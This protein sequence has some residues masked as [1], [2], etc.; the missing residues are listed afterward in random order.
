MYGWGRRCSGRDSTIER[1]HGTLSSNETLDAGEWNVT[2]RAAEMSEAEP[3][4][5][6]DVVLLGCGKMGTALANGWIEGNVVEGDRLYVCDRHPDRAAQL[7]EKTGG[8]KLAEDEAFARRGD[9][10]AR[11]F[12]I[13]VKPGDVR[14]LLE[15]GSDDLTEEDTVVSIAAGVPTQ[16]IDKWAGGSP[17][18]VRAMPNTPAL[19]GRGISGIYDAG[20]AD[21]A[22][23][24]SLFEGVGRVVEIE[25]ESHFDAVTAV[26][27]SGPAYVFTF[28]EALADGA[29]RKG[30]DR[31]TA[32]ELAVETL[33]G[34]AA[35]AR[36]R[37][38]HTAEL[39]DAVASPGGTTINGLAKLEEKG[40]R[41]ALIEAVKSAADRS[42]EM[43]SKLLDDS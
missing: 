32:V 13:A 34:S 5:E 22:V 40:F 3:T 18:V 9:F 23:V 33:F 14:P 29:V 1:V 26:S 8:T 4:I 28:V 25:K 27:G 30:L 20:G 39:K 35:L 7:A 24:R 43:T 6:S 38:E 41:S 19:L 15:R 37:P 42:E 11:I 16:L 36:E 17:A 31:D 12:V 2:E 10:G 21:L